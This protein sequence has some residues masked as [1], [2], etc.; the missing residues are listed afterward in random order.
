MEKSTLRWNCWD[1]ATHILL[2]KPLDSG[3]TSIYN[4]WGGET[5]DM[6]WFNL[7][8]WVSTPQKTL[9][10]QCVSMFLVLVNGSAED[11]VTEVYCKPNDV[12]PKHM[13]Y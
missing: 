1:I 13:N 4:Q 9:Y 2:F 10:S 12:S 8:R 6:F 5:S 11:Q 7:C 3:E